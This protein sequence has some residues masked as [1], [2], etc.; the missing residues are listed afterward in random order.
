M[1]VCLCVC[2]C[3]CV[4]VCLCVCVSVCL[5]VCLCVCVCVCA[6]CLCVCVCLSICLSVCLSVFPFS[7]H[8]R[9]V[10]VIQSEIHSF[11]KARYQETRTVFLLILSYWLTTIPESNPLGDSIQL[12][13]LQAAPSFILTVAF[14]DRWF[15]IWG[16]LSIP[17][18]LLSDEAQA[19]R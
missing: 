2:V 10:P 17:L 13:A 7:F 1:C 3:V 19:E 18:D 5:C 4:S 8:V 11:H 16:R 6:V 12:S 15:G 9:F 14:I